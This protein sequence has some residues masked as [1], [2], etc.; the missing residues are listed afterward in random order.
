MPTYY[1]YGDYVYGI[2]GFARTNLLVCLISAAVPLLAA[3]WLF[4]R[5]AY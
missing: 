4:D 5:K 2:G 1:Y 3:L